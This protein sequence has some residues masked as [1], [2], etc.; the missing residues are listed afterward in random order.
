MDAVDRPGPRTGWAHRGLDQVLQGLGHHSAQRNTD[1]SLDE[2]RP[3]ADVPGHRI[4][5]LN[6]VDRLVELAFT[7]RVPCFQG[8]QPGQ[9]P[10]FLNLGK[11]QLDAFGSQIEFPV[12]AL[13]VRAQSGL[14][15]RGSK[16]IEPLASLVDGNRF[17][18]ARDPCAGG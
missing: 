8:D 9:R 12:T 14:D 15:Q 11:Q 2:E 7:N 3:V 4:S 18:R 1:Q 17:E 6:P 16:S 5:G 13:A 10:H